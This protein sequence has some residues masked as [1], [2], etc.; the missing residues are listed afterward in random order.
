MVNLC[1]LNKEPI[2]NYPTF[3]DYKVI[4]DTH[5]HAGEVFEKLLG[6]REFK[7]KHSNA[8]SSGK[9][10]SF[11]L[12]VYVDSKQ[13]RLDIFEKLKSEAKFVI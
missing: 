11:L 4:F 6:Q 12:S 3:W 10:Q 5:V 8:S 7:Y 1:D 2:I 13:D 9:Y